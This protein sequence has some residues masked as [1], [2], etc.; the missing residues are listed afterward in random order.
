MLPDINLDRT[1]F[2]EMVDRAK[3]RIV[4][5]YPEWTDFN[6]HDPG[7]TLIELFAWRKEIQQYELD[8]IG[9]RHRR[10]YL[11]LLGTDIKHRSAAQCFV[12]ADVTS[13]CRIQEG[14][15]LDAAG[16]TFETMEKQTLP[17]VSVTCCIGWREEMVS[18]LDRDRIAM[19]QPL[20]FYPFG[21]MAREGTCFYIGLSGPL[22]VGERMAL[23]IHV[24]RQGRFPRNPAQKDTIPLAKLRFSCWDGHEYQPVELIREETFGLLYDGQIVFRVNSRMQERRIGEER[25]YFLRVLLKESGY[26]TAP[27]IS[28][29]DMNTMRVQQ[30][31]TVVKWMAASEAGQSD[32]LWGNHNLCNVG[33]VRVFV[34]RNG[35]YK[36]IPVTGKEW[37]E[38]SGRIRIRLEQCG[39]VSSAE[40]FWIL[41]YSEED[42]YM[43]HAV[44]GTAHGFPNESFDLDEDQILYEDLELL[45]EEA[46]QP[47]VY[48]KWER[49]EDFAGSGKSDRHYCVDCITGRILFGNS[50]H[51]MAP[52]GE[53]LLISYS[54]V[55]GSR[56]NVKRERIQ[57]F[58]DQKWAKIKAVNRWDAGGGQ[59][60]ETLEDAFARVRRELKQ[61]RNL[62]TSQ[63]Y[64]QMVRATPGLR[65]ESCKALF[66]DAQDGKGIGNTV[67][68]VVKPYSPGRRPGLTPAF[69]QNI[70]RHL[71]KKRL[72][73]VHIKVLA[74]VYVRLEV[75]VEAVIHPQYQDAESAV[76][77]A[78]EEYLAELKE[79]FGG[80]VSYNGLY[81]YIDRLECVAGIRYLML[82][83]K[84]NE[85]K[86]NSYGDLVF[87]GNGI[88]DEI[89]VRCSCSI[90]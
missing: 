56:G 10:K 68:I 11:Q 15:R 80:T 86:R 79:Q 42:W 59:D 17:G 16:V 46:D 41:A 20:Q 85:A 88:A 44:L 38:A 83:T 71:E 8:H 31:E 33:G 25:G 64:E 45:V 84:G 65:V 48:G 13:P 62:V 37:E 76:R 28:F 55:L 61:P 90:L 18:F 51:G 27:V 73:G 66:G 69:T 81:G 52:E 4:S 24:D 78:V 5:L 47:G 77:L 9:E 50:I 87:P 29:L 43:R 34:E 75:S 21:S 58:R 39:E 36:E 26:E 82:E 1:S 6:Y 19:G 23:T 12:T 40:A 49:R 74:P 54:R 35:L 67:R 57:G 63:D 22:P 89:I 72:L 14:C 7:I 70:L 53:I 60:E 30:K 32:I 2:D 3:N